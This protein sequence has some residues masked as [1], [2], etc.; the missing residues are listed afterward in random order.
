MWKFCIFFLL[1]VHSTGAIRPSTTKDTQERCGSILCRKV[2]EIFSQSKLT[3]GYNY[4]TTIPAGAMNLTIHAMAK[5]NNLIA[6]KTKDDKYIVNGNNRPSEGGFFE[7]NDDTYDYNKE[8][9]MIKA[10]GPLNSPVVL[11]LMVSELNPGIQYS[12]LLP[13]PSATITE[14]EE[15]QSQWNELGQP[16]DEIEENS[17]KSPYESRAKEKRKR[18]Y[19]W[20]LLGF[21]PCSRTCG[22]GKQSPIFRCTRETDSKETVKRY[23]SPKRCANLEKETFLPTIYQCSHGL[24]PPYWK[25]GEFGECECVGGFT[26]GYKRREVFCYQENINGTHVQMDEEK[27]EEARPAAM[28]RCNCKKPKIYARNVEKSSQMYARV[29][30]SPT[31][32]RNVLSKRHTHSN[33]SL[34]TSLKRN[35]REDKAGV[36]LMSDWNHQ[37]TRDCIY[38]YEHR[39]IHCDRTAPYVDPCDPLTQPE[40]KRTC[41]NHSKSC[42]RGM[43]FASDWSKCAG[44]CMNRRRT[45]MILCVMDGFVVDMKQC[46]PKTK[47][48]EATICATKDNAFCGPKW[49]YSEWSECSRSCGEGVQRRYAKCLEYDWKLKEMTESNKCKYLEREPVYGTCH[50]AN[51]EEL[52]VAAHHHHQHHTPASSATNAKLDNAVAVHTRGGSNGPTAVASPASGPGDGSERIEY[53]YDG[54]EVLGY[55]TGEPDEGIDEYIYQDLSSGNEKI[56]IASAPKVL[57]NCR[58]ELNNCKRINRERLCKVDYYKK[59]CCLTCHGY[60]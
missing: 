29:I 24:C 31:T 53:E 60:Y 37:C 26:E 56:V 45:R 7:Y 1:A 15:L 25:L 50:M 8:A 6:L 3:H 46:D 39:T 40:P 5:S 21:G 48:V 28:E 9:S 16:L 4:I 44:D 42:R 54:E 14:P 2:N 17:V 57:Q 27:C 32:I 36:W 41:T 52:R 38:N 30:G 59:Y 13:V 18:K 47:P 35:Y 43:W 20:E 49:H 23:Y 51:C 11:M 12:Y 34:S 33:T 19:A 10:K 55:D 22:P 58:E